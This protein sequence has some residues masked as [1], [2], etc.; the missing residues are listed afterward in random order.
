MPVICE[1]CGQDIAFCVCPA[2][3]QFFEENGHLMSTENGERREQAHKKK[4][5]YIKNDRACISH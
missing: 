5:F 1:Y 4:F 2:V 3:A